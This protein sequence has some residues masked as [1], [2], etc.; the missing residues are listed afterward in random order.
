MVKYKKL[1]KIV[2][3]IKKIKKLNAKIQ[4]KGKIQK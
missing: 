4:K 2:R 3:Y 1:S